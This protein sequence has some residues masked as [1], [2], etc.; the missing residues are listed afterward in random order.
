MSVNWMLNSAGWPAS[1]LASLTMEYSESPDFDDAVSVTLGT[2]IAESGSATLSGLV[3]GDTYWARGVATN[4]VGTVLVIDTFS[5]R[6]SSGA[7]G[8]P[9]FTTTSAT[10][11]FAS[12]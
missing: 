2:D 4:E 12:V 5:F 6:A 8:A 7:G 9:V 3:P 11:F 10:A 1:A